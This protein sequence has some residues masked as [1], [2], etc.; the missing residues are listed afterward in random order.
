M[1][2]GEL[3]TINRFASIIIDWIQTSVDWNFALRSSSIMNCSTAIIIL[4][5]YSLFPVMNNIHT[6]NFSKVRFRKNCMTKNAI[7]FH[8][9]CIY[10]YDV[11]I[12]ILCMCIQ[13]ICICARIRIKQSQLREVWKT[14]S[15]QNII[16]DSGR[17][18]PLN[19]WCCHLALYVRIEEAIYV[20]RLLNAIG[21][22]E[23]THSSRVQGEVDNPISTRCRSYK[24]PPKLQPLPSVR[25][26]PHPRAGFCKLTE[27][28][29]PA[30]D[31]RSEAAVLITSVAINSRKTP[32][33]SGQAR[34]Q[35]IGQYYNIF[36]Y[37]Y[38][39]SIGS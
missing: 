11:Y 12:C 19:I 15:V 30:T 32:K 18:V 4:V 36:V 24:L 26:T 5:W 10:V 29:V 27:H 17:A 9:I 23:F 16:L 6:W 1:E 33:R 8:I 39:S 13:V 22:T 34:R 38:S 21:C 31:N 7:V 25:F 35:R 14:V 2:G 28:S 20:T 37:I 3:Y